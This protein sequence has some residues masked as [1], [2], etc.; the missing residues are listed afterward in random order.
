MNDLIVDLCIPFPSEREADVAYQTL[1]VDAEP[2]R[3]GVTKTLTLKSNTLKATFSGKE[4]RKVRVGLTSFF[5]TLL[6]ITETM[7]EFD[8]PESS[9]DHY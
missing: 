8:P 5:D 1:R 2:S 6:L 7:K 3:S 9:Y 4:A